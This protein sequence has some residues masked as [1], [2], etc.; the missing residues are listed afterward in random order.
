MEKLIKKLI[1]VKDFLKDVVL[2]KSEQPMVKF[3]ENGQW[4]MQKAD[5]PT[6]SLDGQPVTLTGSKETST[7]TFHTVTTASGAERHVPATR[8]KP[9]A[10]A[11]KFRTGGTNRYRPLKQSEDEDKKE[12][13]KKDDEE[14][15]QTK[16]SENY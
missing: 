11:S 6:H 15:S 10:G 12:E 4:S 3:D 1:E 14:N 7:G 8:L 9:I 2:E 5:I 13:N 16:L